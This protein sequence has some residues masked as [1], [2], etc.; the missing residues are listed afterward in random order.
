MLTLKAKKHLDGMSEFEKEL[1][2][3]RIRNIPPINPF[4]VDNGY[5]Y[6][7]K[8]KTLV[9]VE[10]QETNG[11]FVLWFDNQIIEFDRTT[12]N[13]FIVSFSRK[14]LEYVCIGNNYRTEKSLQGFFYKILN[15][16]KIHRIGGNTFHSF[17]LFFTPTS[18]FGQIERLEAV[19]WRGHGAADAAGDGAR[20]RH[21]REDR[22]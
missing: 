5:M 11:V 22:Q 16:E 15:G 3:A 14:C 4:V 2:F 10:I 19:E 21:F 9:C 12:R 6:F 18:V 8:D 17:K 13:C 7:I 20:V 1:I